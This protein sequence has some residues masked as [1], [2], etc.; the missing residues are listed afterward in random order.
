MARHWRS[1]SEANF[2]LERSARW[3]G[4]D[5]EKIA[6]PESVG[7]AVEVP[8]CDEDI[9]G[10]EGQGELLRRIAFQCAAGFEEIG[11]ELA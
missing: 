7:D 3:V 4:A 9:G 1:G 2:L 8:A 5:A 6:I 11:K 10:R